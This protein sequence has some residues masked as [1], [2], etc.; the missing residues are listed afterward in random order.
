MKIVDAD[1]TFKDD[2]FD[3]AVKIYKPNIKDVKA[4]QA[5]IDYARNEGK[6]KPIIGEDEEEM[7]LVQIKDD[8]QYSHLIHP[9]SDLKKFLETFFE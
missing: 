9:V 4:V 8:S 5:I 1:C 7:I 2:G 6:G 3:R